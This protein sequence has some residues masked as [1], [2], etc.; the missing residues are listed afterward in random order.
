MDARV[1]AVTVV[2]VYRFTPHL[3]FLMSLLYF[4]MHLITKRKCVKKEEKLGLK[5]MLDFLLAGN[6]CLNG[7]AC[8]FTHMQTH[9]LKYS[10]K[11]KPGDT[12]ALRARYSICQNLV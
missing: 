2:D 11:C 4:L 1:P 10:S 9:V 7:I 3:L 8:T 5:H 6:K 12:V